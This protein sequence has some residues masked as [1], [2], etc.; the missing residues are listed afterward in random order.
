MRIE[1]LFY[2]NNHKKETFNDIFDNNIKKLAIEQFRLQAT[3]SL[4]FHVHYRHDQKR[5][6]KLR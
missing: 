3:S 1:P 2:K 5:L 6:N 4:S